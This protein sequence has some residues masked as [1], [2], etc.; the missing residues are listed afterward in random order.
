MI[1]KLHQKNAIK[2]QFHWSKE[3]RE[4]CLIS[5]ACAFFVV[6]FSRTFFFAPFWVHIAAKNPETIQFNQLDSFDCFASLQMS[7]KLTVDYYHINIFHILIIFF[8][9][10][11]HTN[12]VHAVLSVLLFHFSIL[13]VCLILEKISNVIFIFL[14]VSYKIYLIIYRRS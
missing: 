10:V 5:I 11:C 13:Q 7:R 2:N 4:N 1:Q 6:V 12:F 9:F 8:F 3:Y 14:C